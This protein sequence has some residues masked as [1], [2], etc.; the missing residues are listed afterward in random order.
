MEIKVS[1][2]V[3]F[4]LFPEYQFFARKLEDALN[5][6]SL[7]GY[8]GKRSRFERNSHA[9]SSNVYKHHIRLPGIHEP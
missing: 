7:S 6:F 5:S 9:M 1:V 8:T 4:E 3:D 2:S